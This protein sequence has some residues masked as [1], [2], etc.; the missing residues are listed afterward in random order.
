ME[1][2]EKFE[3]F[4]KELSVYE[5]KSK[6]RIQFAIL[7]HI[8]FRLFCTKTFDFVISLLMIILI[9]IFIVGFSFKTVSFSLIFHFLYWKF[10]YSYLSKYFEF[11]HY[12]LFTM[13]INIL[14]EMLN[15]K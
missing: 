2:N 12:N 5:T 15:R 1:K 10:F 7:I 6:K 4:R 13:R 3:E 8:F 9:P 11:E 14:K